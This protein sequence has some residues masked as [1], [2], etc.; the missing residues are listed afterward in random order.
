MEK[1]K[2]ERDRRVC[3]YKRQRYENGQYQVKE[4]M[5]QRCTFVERL[6]QLMGPASRSSS[7]CTC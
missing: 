7:L 3:R 2:A 6:R 1:A 4:L 5:K